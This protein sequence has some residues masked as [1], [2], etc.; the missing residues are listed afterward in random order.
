MQTKTLFLIVLTAQT[1]VYWIAVHQSIQAYEMWKESEQ[2]WANAISAPNKKVFIT[3]APYLA[4]IAGKL[5]ISF[6]AVLAF[7]WMVLGAS[8]LNWRIG[9][10]KLQT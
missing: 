6:G 3:F 10:K 2:K 4:T 7:S 8:S 5:A 1:I 9:R